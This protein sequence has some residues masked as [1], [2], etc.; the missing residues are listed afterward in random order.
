MKLILF[1]C[2]FIYI[3]FFSRGLI[4]ILN[5]YFKKN[6]PV[7][8][9]SLFG[10]KIF[11][12]YPILTLFLFGNIS[13][14]LNFFIPSNVS[15]AL[16]LSPILLANFLKKIEIKFNLIEL[17]V[18][19][20]ALFSSFVGVQNLGFHYDSG[21]YHLNSQYFINS[22]KIIFGH[23]N[24]FFQYGFSSIVE[25]LSSIHWIGDNLVLLRFI[26]VPFFILLFNILCTFIINSESV[27]I[28]FS[29]ICVLLYI[30]IDNFGYGG[31]G[32]GSPQF[33]GVGKFD[34]ISSIL[35][36]VC[37]ILFLKT[38]EN[39]INK[40]ELRFYLILVLFAI[41][42]KTTNLPLLILIFSLIVKKIK[43]RY[44]LEF[45]KDNLLVIF[46]SLF[47]M[48]KNLIIS[49]CLFF[50]IKF[51]CSNSLVWSN[52]D[53][54][55]I[56]SKKIYDYFKTTLFE[57]DLNIKIFI[58]FFVFLFLLL[59]YELLKNKSLATLLI[60]NKWLLLYFFTYL[61][62]FLNYTPTLRFLGGV[63]IS[64]IATYAFYLKQN[65]YIEKGLKNIILIPF[66]LFSIILIPRVSQYQT[67]EFSSINDYTL[68]VPKITYKELSNNSLVVPSKG[69]QC[70]INLK[71]IPYED[72]IKIKVANLNYFIYLK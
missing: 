18:F 33:Q 12:F 48:A 58:N 61:I 46:I 60:V 49:G 44:F 27:H 67:S 59:L 51:T 23:V 3:T 41:Q 65:I 31:G 15:I 6:F 43:N 45:I 39:G 30:F 25:Y 66:M 36:L 52:S 21:L 11:Y 37:V 63:L 70:W 54:A 29:S 5:K 16:F 72:E 10:I 40:N 9:D 8:E 50:P 38:I 20:T 47:W 26:Q 62:M 17:L 55:V 28:K 64:I 1:L 53:E 69:E 68:A 35:Q 7:D 22:Q 71:C 56:A 34:S 42:I 13:F 32:N 19:G 14:I 24:L 4:V 57:V 2:Y